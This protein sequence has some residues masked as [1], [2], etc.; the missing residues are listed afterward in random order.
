M[1]LAQWHVPGCLTKWVAG[2]DTEFVSRDGQIERGWPQ[3][4][5]YTRTVAPASHLNGPNGVRSRPERVDLRQTVAGFWD[6]QWAN[7]QTRTGTDSLSGVCLVQIRKGR[8]ARTSAVTGICPDTYTTHQSTASHLAQNDAADKA[9]AG[10][11]QQRTQILVLPCSSYFNAFGVKS[12]TY[13]RLQNVGGKA[14]AAPGLPAQSAESM[15]R[16]RRADYIISWVMVA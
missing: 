12:T 5:S 15:L 3:H 6:A 9:R 11:A 4:Y 16:G 10:I 14:R 1:A 13:I 2:D 8:W 7:S